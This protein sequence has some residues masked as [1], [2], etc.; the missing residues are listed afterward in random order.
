MRDTASL[1]IGLFTGLVFC[2]VGGGLSSFAKDSYLACASASLRLSAAI[3][4]SS[5]LSF[6]RNSEAYDCVPVVGVASESRPDSDVLAVAAC[7]GGTAAAV[8]DG[9]VADPNS[10][11]YRP[12]LL[13]LCSAVVAAAGV[14]ATSCADGDDDEE[15]EA[16]PL[17]ADLI[18]SSACVVV[19]AAAVAFVL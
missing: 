6:S 4:S 10:Y 5:A 13:G 18:Q 3:L 16:P 1:R 14:S 19:V 15:D 12:P 9:A 17:K 11:A 2:G 8:G 7:G